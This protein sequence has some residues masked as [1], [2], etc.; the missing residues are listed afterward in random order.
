MT[1]Q[2]KADAAVSEAPPPPSP[3]ELLERQFRGPKADLRPVYDALVHIAERV[4]KS[5]RAEPSAQAIL[6][7]RKNPFA[8]VR[9]R[10]DSIELG[11]A[12]PE[13][14]A[15]SPRLRALRKG[16]G[17][18]DRITHKVELPG[19]VAVNADVVLW[20]KRACEL[21]TRA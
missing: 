8:I 20:M 16:M 10:K 19:L 14:E 13:V 15:K 2:E 3:E 5:V 6:F 7:V 4:G 1:L 21:A 17:G 11:L 12:L 18:C 9:V